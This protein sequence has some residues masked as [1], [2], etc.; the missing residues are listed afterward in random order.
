MVSPRTYVPNSTL[1]EFLQMF[2]R[3]RSY[4]PQF[5][6]HGI[7]RRCI[8]RVSRK[9]FHDSM[10]P[11]P[12]KAPVEHQ[13]A[14][15]GPHDTCAAWIS[16]LWRHSD[17]CHSVSRDSLGSSRDTASCAASF[18]SLRSTARNRGP[19]RFLFGTTAKPNRL[20]ERAGL[21]SS[22]GTPVDAPHGPA[23]PAG[24]NASGHCDAPPRSPLQ[25]NTR[26]PTT[27]ISGLNSMVRHR[28]C[29]RFAVAVADAHARLAF[30]C[31]PNST[32]T[33]PLVTM[34]KIAAPKNN[35]LR[36]RRLPSF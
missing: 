19:G 18:R 4:P 15:R 27:D 30:G 20:A 21:S 8:R 6:G 36:R 2:F 7:G 11:F 3:Q 1:E 16:V 5:R 10:S 31:W 32:W 17:S 14:P 24:A 9:R 13:F 28:R 34:G 26:T 33:A 35:D 29:L 23:T 22:W 25:L 12:V